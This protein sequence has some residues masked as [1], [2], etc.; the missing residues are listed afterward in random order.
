VRHTEDNIFGI[1]ALRSVVDG[2]WDCAL[3]SLCNTAYQTLLNI[4]SWS[5]LQRQLHSSFVVTR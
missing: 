4:D 2:Q 5:S 3:L 1:T